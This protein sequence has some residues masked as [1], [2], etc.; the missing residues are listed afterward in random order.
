MS[1]FYDSPNDYRNYLCHYGVKGMKWRH[2]RRSQM[3][4][5]FQLPGH[6]VAST[7]NSG[8]RGPSREEH[9]QEFEAQR[10][11]NPVRDHDAEFEAQRHPLGGRR[12]SLIGREGTHPNAD[13]TVRRVTPESHVMRD[14][15][16]RTEFEAQ[17]YHN[18]AREHDAEFEAQ[19]HPTNRRKPEER[20][21]GSK[22]I[23][24]K[25]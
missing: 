4:K 14:A 10:Y 7:R 1:T 6:G 3:Q 19:R 13:S 20:S 5:N 2:H 15:L 21:K 24:N 25:R 11:H 17:R 12:R 22:K 16:H 18:P 23:K 8:G 9:E